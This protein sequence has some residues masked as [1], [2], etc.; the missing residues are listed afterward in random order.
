M[1]V[2]LTFRAS[3]ILLISGQ[4]ASYLAA[5]PEF[6]E[7]YVLNNVDLD[8]L[9]RWTIRRARNLRNQ[10]KRGGNIRGLIH[11]GLNRVKYKE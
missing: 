1:Y 2:D 6:L 8:T 3:P 9:E 5:N 7:N 10:S 11:L 4:V